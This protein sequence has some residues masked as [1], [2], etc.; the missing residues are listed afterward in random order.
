MAEKIKLIRV[1][2]LFL[3]LFLAAGWFSSCAA[4]EPSIRVAVIQD[5]PS[6]RLKVKGPYT[7]ID[8]ASGN[9][10]YRG[11]DI[12][13]TVTAGGGK[14]LLGKIKTGSKK[15]LI[16]PQVARSVL[17][18]GRTFR[19]DI[20][21]T[22]GSSG[23]TVINEIG[24]EDYIR[25]ILYH[26][27]SHYWPKD[28]L[29]AQAI[30][31]RTYAVYQK[32]ESRLRDYD[33]T[34]DIYSQVYGGMSAERYRTNEA[35]SDT[36]GLILTYKG[37]VFP[38]YFHAVCAGHTE[39][40]SRLWDIDLYP[41]KGVACSFCKQAPHYEWHYVEDLDKIALK[42]S[43]SGY[44]TGK[45]KSIDI[46]GRDSSS[47]II[48]LKVSGEKAE[49]KISAKDFRQALGPNLVRSTNF[50]LHIAA[51]D[52]VFEGFGW[53]HGVGLC[54]WGAYFMAKAG[55]NYKDILKFYYPGSVIVSLDL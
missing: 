15:L 34:S 16:K 26:E 50:E 18:D 23:I 21:L 53:G 44:H 39:D 11:E 35:V 46:S 54:Q 27:V 48:F 8:T 33:V 51:N 36:A 38:A 2:S 4:D 45:I 52:A 5:A 24:I 42:L 49:V 9:T 22:A 17:I 43:Q 28:A 32:Q 31:C 20:R 7:V 6:V 37:K 1:I 47:R 12:N 13:T 10:I 41:L 3:P 25:G 29:C 30:A 40:A 19:G 14:M 55:Y